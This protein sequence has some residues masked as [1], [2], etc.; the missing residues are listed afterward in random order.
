TAGS[1]ITLAAGDYGDVLIDRQKYAS[2]VTIKSADADEPAT[3][4]TIR[5]M[6][7]SNL[8]LDGIEVAFKPT[9]TTVLFDNAVSISGS[10]GVSVVN[11]TIHGGPAINGVLPTET[12]LD[13]SRNVLGLPT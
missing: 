12:D 8:T 10:N 7:S 4:N 5:I 2:E 1:T 6:N 3:F 13:A 9:T 11:S